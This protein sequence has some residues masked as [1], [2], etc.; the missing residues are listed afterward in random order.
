MH[1]NL[2]EVTP[3]YQPTEVGMYSFILEASDLANNSRFIRRLCFYDPSS[4]ITLLTKALKID[5]ARGFGKDAWMSNIT[6]LL[7][8][9]WKDHFV[10]KIHE[11]NKLLN[12]VKEYL[13]KLDDGYKT[14]DQDDTYGRRTT[15]G[16]TNSRGIV[17][18]EVAHTIDSNGGRGQTEPTTAWQHFS[19]SVLSMTVMPRNLGSGDTVTVWVRATDITGRNKTDFIRVHYDSTAPN[20]LNEITFKRNVQGTYPFGSK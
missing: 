17:E 6:S 2:S 15:A 10:N 11:H 13:Q 1:A 14:I 4:E 12:P 19:A 16:I 7:N 9:S 8:I 20:A 3:S 5:S 18:F